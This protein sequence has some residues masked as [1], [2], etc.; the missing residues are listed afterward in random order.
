MQTITV[1]A[2]TPYP[3]HI[4]PSHFHRKHRQHIRPVGGRALDVNAVIAPCLQRFQLGIVGHIYRSYQWNIKSPL[5]SSH[6]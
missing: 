5:A 2:S 4:G 3:V 6:F 1:N